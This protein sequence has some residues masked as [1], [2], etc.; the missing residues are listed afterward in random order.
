MKRDRNSEEEDIVNYY[1][2]QS[3][4][5][6]GIGRRG[7]TKG[8][9]GNWTKPEANAPRMPVAAQSKLPVPPVGTTERVPYLY[10]P[11]SMQ[12]LFGRHA[13]LFGTL[14]TIIGFLLFLVVSSFMPIFGLEGQ[15]LTRIIICLILAGMFWMMGMSGEMRPTTVGVKTA[16]ILGLYPILSSMFLG[17]VQSGWGLSTYIHEIMTPSG[18]IIAVETLLLCLLIG[19]FEEMLT[20]GIFLSGL[21]SRLGKSSKGLYAAA[22]ISAIFFGF[23]H[24]SSEAVL[25]VM[26][27]IPPDAFIILQMFLKTVQTG[28]LGVLLAAITIRTHSI[29]GATLVHALDD[30]FLMLPEALSGAE[31]FIR[32]A[33]SFRQGFLL[34]A[35]MSTSY[36]END[37]DKAF[38][39]IVL[40][41]ILCLTYIPYL[42]TAGKLIKSARIPDTGAMCEE[43][44]AHEIE[45]YD[46]KKSLMFMY[47]LMPFV[48]QWQAPAPQQMAIPYQMQGRPYWANTS[49][50]APTIGQ[51]AWQTMPQPTWGQPQ[52]TQQAYQQMYQQGYQQYSPTGRQYQ[53]WPQPPGPNRFPT[54]GNGPRW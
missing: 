27:K 28:M 51:V 42:F 16:L 40:Y 37:P 43:Y 41:T 21:Q 50:A 10:P 34:N 44:V 48:S 5:P 54:G 29:W 49:M 39:M 24:V 13:L 20:R 9:Y 6:N 53:Q 25:M 8:E 7:F 11:G 47:P 1:P 52:V 46:N 26:G 38:V 23:L 30:Y 18:L 33:G 3:V 45:E 17:T 15:I 31:L 35:T 14:M 12:A 32:G 22:Y 2:P 4:Q 19:A 36:V